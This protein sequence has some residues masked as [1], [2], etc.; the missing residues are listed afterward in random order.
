MS[1]ALAVL[2]ALACGK[3]R[4]AAQG[5]YAKDVAEAVPLIERGTGLK[6]KRPPVLETRSKQQ[7]RQF[8]EERFRQ[9]LPDSEIQGEQLLYRRLGLIPD[10]LDLRK[11]MLD[12]LTEQVAGFYDPKTKKLYVVDGAP[13]EQVS[14]IISHELVHALQDQYMNLD[15]MQ[16]VRGEND[17]SM[18][19]QAVIEGQATLLPIQAM[20]GPGASMPAGWDRVREMIRDNQTQMP[21]LASAPFVL[22]ETLIFPYLTGA[23]FMRR[24]GAER[25]GQTPYGANMPTSTEQVLHPDRYFAAHRDLPTRVELPRPAAGSVLYEDDLGEFETRLFL[26][27][28][29]RDQPEALRGAAGWDGDRYEV[30][31]TPRGDGIL[32]LTVW[33]SPVDAAEFSSDVE[34]IAGKRFARARAADVPGG[35]RWSIAGGR[36]V[37]LWGGTVAGR[38]A[39]LYS[40]L[41][42]GI[43]PNLL[44]LKKV[45]LDSL[46]R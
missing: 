24:F 46:A 26:F 30:V 19:A 29:L 28:H 9:E 6:F 1:A 33:D 43:E 3:D 16:D 15:S 18:A 12:L 21:V 36:V 37:A 38:P 44:D 2:L 23:E 22:Q 10:T 17:R 39:V 35:K 41:P 14:M 7:V 5:P 13:P 32:W 4:G 42:D 40:D 34:Q 31:R 25:P 45:R 27:Q 8:L 11:F 20:L